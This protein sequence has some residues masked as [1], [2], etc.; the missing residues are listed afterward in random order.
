DAVAG[1]ELDLVI[2][3]SDRL[4]DRTPQIASPDAVFDR[5]VA[6][7]TFPIDSIGA[8]TGLDRGQL[9]EGDS[10]ARRCD[11]AQPFD[12]LLGVSIRLQVANHKV[13]PAL[14]LK[15]LRDRVAADGCLN[16]V[17]HVCDIELIASGLVAIHRDVQVW[18]ADDPE[19]AKVFD[20]ANA[21]HDP[22]NLI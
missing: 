20:A 12:R 5:D 22:E 8:V 18:L 13:I 4:F 9:R 6:G 21:A 16:G 17:L 14:A 10:L 7:V 3:F 2:D 19:E 15:H 1:G 11:Q